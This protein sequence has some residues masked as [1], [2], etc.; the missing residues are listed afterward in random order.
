MYLHGTSFSSALSIE[1]KGAT[2]AFFITR[3]PSEA[4]GYA[5]KQAE[6]DRSEPVV[7]V[8]FLNP[9]TA[10]K[11]EYNK[12]FIMNPVLNDAVLIKETERGTAENLEILEYLSAAK[13]SDLKIS[14][15]TGASALLIAGSTLQAIEFISVL[16]S[17]TGS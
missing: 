13:Y 16:G 10:T 2:G 8:S 17:N 6:A 14:M 3:D 5:S 11:N 15:Q 9:M 4:W 7:I 1:R 12:Y